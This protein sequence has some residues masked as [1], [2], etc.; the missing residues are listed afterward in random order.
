[1]LA[2]QAQPWHLAVRAAR[3]S[4]V[5]TEHRVEAELSRYPI[6]SLDLRTESASR[7]HNVRSE[8]R[9][10]QVEAQPSTA[11]FAPVAEVWRFSWEEYTSLVGCTVG[12][13]GRYATPTRGRL[14]AASDGIFTRYRSVSDH[15][16]RQIPWRVTAYVLNVSHNARA[17]SLLCSNSFMFTRRTPAVKAGSEARVRRSVPCTC[18]VTKDATST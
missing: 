6:G 13:A 9:R 11:G 15:V 14:C 17:S 8:S 4:F 5:W 16:H 18:L 3:V 1:M 7:T 12:E 10:S 2:R